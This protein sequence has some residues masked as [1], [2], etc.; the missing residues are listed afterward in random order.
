[1]WPRGLR[2]FSLALLACALPA[3]SETGDSDVEALVAGGA[4]NAAAAANGGFAAAVFSQ[5]TFPPSLAIDGRMESRRGWAYHGRLR[6]ASILFG[7]ECA[8][9]IRRIRL[10][11]GLGFEDHKITSFE[12]W[13]WDAESDPAGPDAECV[14]SAFRERLQEASED[15]RAMQVLAGETN[16]RRLANVRVVG[17]GTK[18]DGGVLKTADGKL[19]VSMEEASLA[20]LKVVVLSTDAETNNGV[21]T[22]LEAYGTKTARSRGRSTRVTPSL[23]SDEV[24][25]GPTLAV[26]SPRDGSTTDRG[27]LEYRLD[28]AVLG[29][30]GL[31]IEVEMDG[32][33]IAIISEDLKVPLAMDRDRRER[34]TGLTWHRVKLNLLDPSG[35]KIGVSATS[36][37]RLVGPKFV[38]PGPGQGSVA[39]KNAIENSRAHFPQS[40]PTVCAS[41]LS[42]GR[43]HLLR[44]TMRSFIR[45]MEAHE[46]H[47]PYEIAWIDQGSG[48]SA[49]EFLASVEV[50]HALMWRL[51][52]GVTFG[53]NTLL[54]N[55]C[56]RSRHAS[57]HKC[58]FRGAMHAVHCLMIRSLR[59]CGEDSCVVFGRVVRIQSFVCLTVLTPCIGYLLTHEPIYLHIA[60]IRLHSFGCLIILVVNIHPM[61]G[62]TSAQVCHDPGGGL[63]VVL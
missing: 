48:Q 9:D 21:L 39:A 8:H 54:F 34:P 59:V 60:S 7:F 22:E 46:P 52:Y 2:V 31:R 27:V 53:I 3:C 10:V 49:L 33:A 41:F 44:H 13:A 23:D 36:R 38:V 16:W 57:V 56:R 30:D 4:S 63:A 20:G 29:D 11:S 15:R 26:I 58:T 50:E 28:G 19:E 55:L 17:G 12:L 43:V 35:Q 40:N 1:M 61:C 14:G 62:W 32:E 5:E 37:F 6:L 24:A 45:H 25:L 51:N 18:A 47:I 42:C